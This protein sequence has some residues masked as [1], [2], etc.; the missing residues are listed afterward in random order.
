[1]IHADEPPDRTDPKSRQRLPE[2]IRYRKDRGGRY[3]VRVW[4]ISRN[5]EWRERTTI[6]LGYVPPEQLKTFPNLKWVQSWNAGIEMSESMGQ[7]DHVMEQVVSG[8]VLLMLL[9]PLGQ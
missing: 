8:T 1:M 9:T 7:A 3:Q 2:G 4:G 6:L 5:G